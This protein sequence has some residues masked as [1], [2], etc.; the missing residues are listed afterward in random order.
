[1]IPYV[2]SRY[3]GTDSFIIFPQDTITIVTVI[4]LSNLPMH[5]VYID[6]FCMIKQEIM[7]KMLKVKNTFFLP[8]GI[9]YPPHEAPIALPI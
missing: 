8:F 5:N 4:P 6:K 9:N 2:S 7:D 3:T 1:M